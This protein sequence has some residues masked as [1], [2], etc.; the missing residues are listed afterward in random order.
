MDDI[1]SI[2]DMIQIK[3][4]DNIRN[5]IYRIPKTDNKIVTLHNKNTTI[6]M[7]RLIIIRFGLNAR[8]NERGIVM[9]DNG[10]VSISNEKLRVIKVNTILSKAITYKLIQYL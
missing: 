10:V 4:I 2:I 1:K 7:K 6:N 9:I 3:Y 5:F 8:A